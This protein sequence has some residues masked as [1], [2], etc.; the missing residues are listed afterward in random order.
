MDATTVNMI[1][2][3]IGSLGF[4]IFACV[5]MMYLN[6]KQTEA[7]AQ[8]VEKITEA[9]TELKIAINNLISKIG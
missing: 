4:P 2:S 7:H 3:L 8:E 9:I 6:Q 1:A 5:Y